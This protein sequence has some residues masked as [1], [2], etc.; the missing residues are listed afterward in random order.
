MGYMQTLH[1][2]KLEEVLYRRNKDNQEG[3][4]QPGDLTVNSSSCRVSAVTQSDRSSHR[5]SRVLS[6]LRS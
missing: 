5:P 6:R 2:E 4:V 3:L 1:W